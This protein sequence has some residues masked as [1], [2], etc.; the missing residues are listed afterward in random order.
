MYVTARLKTSIPSESMEVWK[1]RVSS[2]SASFFQGCAEC[3]RPIDNV[4]ST[5]ITSY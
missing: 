5:S 4:N 2:K 3:R 1:T